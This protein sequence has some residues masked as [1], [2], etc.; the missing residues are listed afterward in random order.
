MLLFEG[1]FFLFIV[2]LTGDV[3]YGNCR[4]YPV[5]APWKGSL[6]I[7]WSMQLHNNK[8]INGREQF[9]ALFLENVRQVMI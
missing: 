9:T 4:P 8:G 3:F 5:D 6:S 2:C 7:G 1:F